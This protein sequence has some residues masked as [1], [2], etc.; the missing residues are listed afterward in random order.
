MNNAVFDINLESYKRLFEDLKEGIYFS[1]VEGEILECN[2]AFLDI[3]GYSLDELKNINARDFYKFPHERIEFQQLIAEKGFVKDFKV[4]IKR[5]DKSTIVCLI[6]ASPFYN[7]KKDII[8]YS[9]ILRDISFREQAKKRIEEERNKRLL[10]I[11][12]IQ[13]RA[14]KKI[15]MEIHD[16]LGQLLFGIKLKMNRLRKLIGENHQ[17]STLIAD[18]DK[19]IKNAID[20]SRRVSRSLRPSVLDDFGIVAALEQLIEQERNNGNVK[21]DFKHNG[22]NNLILREQIQVAIYRILQ[23]ALSNAIRHGK[24]KKIIISLK[25]KNEGLELKMSD[26]GIG[27]DMKEI[28]M[29]HGLV[30]MKERAEMLKG[31]FKPKSTPGKGTIIKVVIPI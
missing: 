31:F 6:S 28:E 26:D 19:A 23:E 21:I 4:T 1:T 30:N 15:A 29:G 12:Y 8:G 5:K 20:E 17:Q 22:I 10:D 14:K 27:F 24:A 25:L 9:G 13:E 2:Q 7:N 3:T 16:G 18:I 11:T